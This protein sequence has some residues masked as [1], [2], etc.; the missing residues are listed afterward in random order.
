VENSASAHTR[1]S[2]ERQ[3]APWHVEF[4]MDLI[5]L[6]LSDHKILFDGFFH[7]TH[8]ASRASCGGSA[9]INH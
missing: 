7:A 2:C 1:S 3:R 9:A 6:I 5:F 4:S 8:V